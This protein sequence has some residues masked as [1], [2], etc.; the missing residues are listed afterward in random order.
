MVVMSKFV[1]PY[2]PEYSAHRGAEKR[3]RD[4]KN[5]LRDREREPSSPSIV[6]EQAERSPSVGQKLESRFRTIPR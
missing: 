3:H 5:W 6:P 4:T 2:E 1:L